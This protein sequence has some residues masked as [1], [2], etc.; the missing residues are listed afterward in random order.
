MTHARNVD[1]NHVWSQLMVAAEQGLLAQTEAEID[2]GTNVNAADE[3]GWTP[4]HLAAVNDHAAIV[5]LLLAQPDIKTNAQNKWKS[6]P[7]ILAASRGN[8]SSIRLLLSHPTT[9]INCQAEY[10]G[11][12]A[13]IEAAKNGHVD[14][15][16]ML[17]EKG[18]DVNLRD[19]TGRNTALIEAM[20]HRHEKIVRFLLHSGTIDFSDKDTRLNALIW[21]GNA[22][23]PEVRDELD[24]AIQNF[25]NK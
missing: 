2:A 1:R 7:L 13:L 19:K 4:L 18:A 10:Y 3:D 17:I 5:E 21:A 22:C 16:E 25:F 11:R 20:K 9:D 14:V 8:I 6:T 23:S 24:F 12:T 15:A